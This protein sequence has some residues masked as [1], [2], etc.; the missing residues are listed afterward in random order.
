[1]SDRFEVWKGTERAGRRWIRRRCP[2]G[3]LGSLSDRIT[4]T[5]KPLDWFRNAA[6]GL[7]IRG[8]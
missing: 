3:E 6:P 4:E 8:E 5:E 1:M 2:A 7:R